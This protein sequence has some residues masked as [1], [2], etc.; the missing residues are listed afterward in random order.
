MQKINFIN[1]IASVK[2][3]FSI[4][5]AKLRQCDV[6]ARLLPAKGSK[7]ADKKFIMSEKGNH[8][9]AELFIVGSKGQIIVDHR[10]FVS[11]SKEHSELKFNGQFYFVELKHPTLGEATT[12]EW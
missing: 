4:D 3:G 2:E 8:A 10:M 12:E 6:Y 5:E 1:G 11:V 7:I 9:Q